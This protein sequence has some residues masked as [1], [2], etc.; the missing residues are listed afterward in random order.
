MELVI[1]EE[2]NYPP[3]GTHDACQLITTFTDDLIN[4]YEIRRDNKTILSVEF[5]SSIV[6]D[7]GPRILKLGS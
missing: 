5:G 2:F 1:P 3:T 6:Y 4:C 7:N